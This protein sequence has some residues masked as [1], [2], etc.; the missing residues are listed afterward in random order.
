MRKK[1]IEIC[2]SYDASVILKRPP[3]P[4]AF[5]SGYDDILNNFYEITYSDC[6]NLCDI[7]L[8][9]MNFTMLLI[10]YNK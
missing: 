3:T 5:F 1:R 2:S 4:G 6:D 8:N 9:L 7:R 10:I